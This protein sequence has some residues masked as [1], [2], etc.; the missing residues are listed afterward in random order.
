MFAQYA[1]RGSALL[2]RQAAQEV[3]DA[4]GPQPVDRGAQTALAL[5]TGA[6]R[7]FEAFHGLMEL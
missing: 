4:F 5:V 2:C 7:S 1:Q 6:R 3:L